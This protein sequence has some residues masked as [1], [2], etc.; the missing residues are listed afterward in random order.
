MDNL[1][2]KDVIYIVVWAVSIVVT[3]LSTKH[4]IENKIRDKTDE[5]DKKFRDKIEDQNKKITELEKEQIHLKH[6]D[7]MQQQAIDEFRKQS[8]D[9]IPNLVAILAEKTNSK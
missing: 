4:Q 9:Y 8:F 5:I 2:I 1:G 3:F 6:R 7:E